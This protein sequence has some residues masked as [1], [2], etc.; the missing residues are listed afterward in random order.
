[1]KGPTVTRN[2]VGAQMD[3]DNPNASI[4]PYSSE[5]K[6]NLSADLLNTAAANFANGK[7]KF[8][9][10]TVSFTTNNVTKQATVEIGAIGEFH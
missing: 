1:M 8:T 5:L 4:D 2:D 3:Y 9:K 10:A 6:T 7:G